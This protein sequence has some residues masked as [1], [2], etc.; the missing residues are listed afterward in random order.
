M[1]DHD[2]LD[3]EQKERHDRLDREQKEYHDRLDREQKEYHARCERQSRNSFVFSI[4][5]QTLSL[6]IG[7][8]VGLFILKLMR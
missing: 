3:R 1:I 8:M 4:V 2:R 6:T 5:I 7:V